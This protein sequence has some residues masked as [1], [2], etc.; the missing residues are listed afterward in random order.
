MMK[1]RPSAG[2]LAVKCW[3]DVRTILKY[4]QTTM[5]TKLVTTTSM[6]VKTQ[7]P[8]IYDNNFFGSSDS[9]S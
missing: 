7:G 1:F 8:M 4:F 6:F 3:W 5:G 2:C 9:C